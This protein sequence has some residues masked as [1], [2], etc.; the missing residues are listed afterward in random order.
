M[1]LLGP[2]EAQQAPDG[3]RQRTPHD[4]EN[5]P[6]LHVQGDGRIGASGIRRVFAS[7]VAMAKCRH[8]TSSHTKNEAAAS[9]DDWTV[10]LTASVGQVPRELVAQYLQ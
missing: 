4:H 8:G 1:M 2:P 6:S 5:D 9:K 3:Q 7:S 10:F